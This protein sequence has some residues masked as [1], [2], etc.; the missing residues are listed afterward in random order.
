MN[1]GACFEVKCK[2]DPTAGR[3]PIQ[4][5]R[6]NENEKVRCHRQGGIKF[7]LTG[8][9]YFNLVLV[10]NVGGAGNVY[11]MAVKGSETKYFNQISRNLGQ[12]WQ[13]YVRLNSK[14]NG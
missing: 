2:Y 13:Y 7:T 8:K 14:K 11:G 1:C 9:P 5:R 4:Y 3:I 10:Y 12:Y 6:Y